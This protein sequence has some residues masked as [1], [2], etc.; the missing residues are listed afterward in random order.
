M[1]CRG[2][3]RGTRRARGGG[4]GRARRLDDAAARR[5]TVAGRSGLS[6]GW[7][8]AADRSGR[9]TGRRTGAGR[10]AARGLCG[11][12]R[13]HGFRRYRVERRAGRYAGCLGR[14]R[15]VA[16][17][18]ASCGDRHR[19]PGA[20]LPDPRLDLAWRDDRGRRAD[21]AQDVRAGRRGAGH[22]GGMRPA[23]LA[24]SLAISAG[25]RAHRRHARHDAAGELA[26]RAASPARVPHVVL[27]RPGTEPDGGG[28]PARAGDRRCPFAERRG[29]RAPGARRLSPGRGRRRNAR[30]RSPS[31]ASGCRA[32]H[33]PC[34]G[35]G[36]PARLERRPALLP[37]TSRSVAGVQRR[38]DLDRG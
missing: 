35:R 28:A 5:A 32:E 8:D 21:P 29:R 25:R 18:R 9:D 38:H 10:K 20:P 17:H 15:G 37:S 7:H 6:R 24:A 33:Q 31:A 12:R 14:R 16:D 4:R 36:V 13:A 34:P 19:R 30:R 11:E 2:D 23:A 3:R 27:S 1:R 26:S 22:A